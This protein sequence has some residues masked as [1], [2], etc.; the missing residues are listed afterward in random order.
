M[1]TDSIKKYKQYYSEDKISCRET[2]AGIKLGNTYE[3]MMIIQ[4]FNPT[5]FINSLVYKIAN[6]FLLLKTH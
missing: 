1:L 4:S 3:L 2:S 6:K 5:N